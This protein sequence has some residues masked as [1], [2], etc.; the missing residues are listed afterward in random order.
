M[1]LKLNISPCPNDT[2]MFDALIHAR[3]D[4]EGLEFDVNYLDI[5]QL[6][7][8]VTQDNT[9]DISKIS[10]AILPHILDNYK[11]LDSGSALGYGNG[12]LV[13]S[14]KKGL[15]ISENTSLICPGERTT[16]RLLIAKIFPQIKNIDNQ[17]FCDIAD[18]VAAKK[19][20]AGVIIHEGRFT[21]AEK[22][23]H[24]VADLGKEWEQLT[25][26]PLPLGAI[27]V[28]K[29]LDENLMQKINRVLK[30]SILYAQE[31]PLASRE[32]ILSHA[33]EL[34]NEVIENHINMFVNEFSVSLT[35]KGERAVRELCGINEE[36]IFVK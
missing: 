5:E 18:S 6:N 36:N 26:L 9:I 2:F 32:F 20:D 8:Q 34:S 14:H 23:L 15:E 30:R 17:I 22:N 35:S 1:K 16:A 13:V 31:N 21:F 27:V 3:V 11:A 24:L 19:Y 33:Q 25:G 7:E 12:P 4:T 28:N 10:Y 29:N